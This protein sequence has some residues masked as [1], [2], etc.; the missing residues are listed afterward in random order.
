MPR[1][2]KR[3]AIPEVKTSDEETETEPQNETTPVEETPAEEEIADEECGCGKTIDERFDP[4]SKKYDVTAHT[5]EILSKK[6]QI[7]FIIPLAENEKPGAFDSVQIN[8]YK[9]TIQKGVMV[10]IPLPCAE[11][12]AAKYRIN[13]EA[14]ANSRLDRNPAIREALS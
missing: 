12:L 7:N 13:L 1:G 4:R 10:T 2:I 8:G 14:G 11:L 9:L 3:K 5:K 6:P